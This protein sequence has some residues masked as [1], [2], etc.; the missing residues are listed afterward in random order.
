MMKPLHV[1]GLALGAV[2]LGACLNFDDNGGARDA[3]CAER[4]DICPVQATPPTPSQPDASTPATDG[5]TDAGSPEEDGGSDAGT[6][7][8]GGADAGTPVTDGGADGGGGDPPP[9]PNV[10]F[11]PG[12]VYTSGDLG[13]GFARVVADILTP[14]SVTPLAPEARKALVHPLDGRL[15]Y[16]S[17]QFEAYEWVADRFV[18]NA[19]IKR[20]SV[21]D[22]ALR[23]ERHLAHPCPPEELFDLHMRPDTGE[24]LFECN[25]WDVYDS[26]GQRFIPENHNLVTVGHRGF[27]LTVPAGRDNLDGKM[28]LLDADNTVVPFIG[29]FTANSRFNGISAMRTTA[30]GFHLVFS[31]E[32]NPNVPRGN[33]YTLWE[34]KETGEVAK[35]GS[36]AEL[37]EG[38][39][40]MGSAGPVLGPDGVL[41]LSALSAAEGRPTA[42]FRL[43]LKPEPA[44]LVYSETNAPKGDWQQDLSQAYIRSSHLFFTGP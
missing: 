21:S 12:R 10:R 4:P 19:S 43:P 13:S 16:L 44:V 9:L 41:W 25:L 27:K 14:S 37:P 8:D 5:G 22:D 18:W 20:Y 36:Y 39:D 31:E 6:V 26:Q 29:E 40:D 28:F 1:T 30:D 33:W 3:F 42:I 32:P 11:D 24:L 34:V 17:Y 7:P 35:R 23:N 38:Y 15:F 2:V